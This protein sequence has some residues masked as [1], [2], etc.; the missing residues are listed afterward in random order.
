MNAFLISTR[1][2]STILA[3][4]ICTI[5]ASSGGLIGFASNSYQAKGAQTTSVVSTIR[6]QVAV[7]TITQ[8]FRN[9]T[10]TP[11]RAMYGFPLSSAAMVTNL[12]WNIGGKWYKA[13]MNS[14]DS[15]ANCSN[16]SVTTPPSKAF[17]STFSTPPFTFAFKD[18]IQRDS[19]II[20]ELTYV[21]L[22]PYKNDEVRYQ[23]IAAPAISGQT[24]TLD[25]IIIDIQ[26][27]RSI[28]EPSSKPTILSIASQTDKTVRFADSMIIVRPE[29]IVVSFKPYYDSLTMN[30]LS[31]KPTNE[32]GYAL[33][34]A[35]P[36][37]DQDLSTVI[38]KR[39]TFVLDHSGS[40]NFDDRL[41]RAKQ[42]AEHCIRN[43]GPND[44]FNVV[45]FN[46]KSASC[47]PQHRPYISSNEQLALQFINQTTAYGGT[48]ITSALITALSM[49]RSDSYVNAIIFITDGEAQVDFESIVR[50]NTSGTRIF[51]F[52]VGKSVNEG[53]L[54]RIA[55]DNNGA[56]Y[57]DD[58]PSMAL[59]NIIMMYD[60]IKDPI[61][62]NPKISF[63]PAV[64]YDTYPDI[65]PDIYKGQQLLLVGRYKKPGDVIVNV[66]G[67]NKQGN[68]SYPF[69]ANLTDDPNIN[70]FVE[71]IWAKYRIDM[72]LVWMKSEPT[73]S[74]RYKEWKEEVVRLGLKYGIVTSFT[75]LGD[76]GKPDDGAT[77]VTN[78][79]I[80]VLTERLR[81]APNPVRDATTITIDLSSIGARNIR[82]EIVDQRGNIVAVLY[83]EITAPDQLELRWNGT[84][85]SGNQVASGVYQLVV[86]ADGMQ[87]VANI[88][89]V[90]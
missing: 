55:R 2:V 26:C 22:L 12:R 85:Q 19:Q 79:G 72:L 71:K 18:T 82:V 6:E 90:R 11:S 57:F 7:T 63:S 17:T 60:Q 45:V 83:D 8:V 37:S 34:M 49:H 38:P 28:S 23:Y 76:T 5:S 46:D 70:I 15:S 21:E 10:G 20:V 62:K 24:V 29:G 27:G 75:T 1:T 77:S 30:V 33:M 64:V 40:M 69:A 52:G 61:I 54:L 88:T 56:A 86:T 32:D 89:V 48:D 50:A 9:T 59:L 66:T 43:L 42:A 4:L 16:D 58:V 84:D 31:T 65:V 36:G 68:V 35:V 47:F 41:D 78:D 53:T 87:S 13:V 3:I 51:V 14:L 80:N 67:T 44:L 73:T 25:S 39:F 74:S 81:I